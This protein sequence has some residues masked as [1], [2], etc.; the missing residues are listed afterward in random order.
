MSQYPLPN[1]GKRRLPVVSHLGVLKR[2]LEDEHCNRL[3]EHKKMR[4]TWAQT[5]FGFILLGTMLGGVAYWF[6]GVTL[7]GTIGIVWL[8]IMAVAWFFSSKIAPL[9]VSA[10]AA[11]PGTPY[12]DRAIRCADRAW[13]LLIE[14]VRQHYGQRVADMLTRPPVKLAPSKH[15][16]AFCTGRGWHDSVIVI[17]EG[18]VDAGMSDDEIVAVLAHELGHY[19]HGDVFIQ[20]VAGVLGAILSL[21]VTGFVQRWISPFFGRLHWIFRWPGLVLLFV[22]F[23]FA[24]SI[25]KVV[26]MFISRAREASADAFAADVTDDPCALARALRKLVVHEKKLAAEEAAKDEQLRLDDPVEF[27]RRSLVRTC[28]FAVLDALGLM[29]FVDT[30]ECLHHRE[31]EPAES[32]IG[33]LAQ[34][35]QRLNENHPPVEDRCAWLELAAGRACPLEVKEMPGKEPPAPEVSEPGQEPQ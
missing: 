7:L 31:S 5:L 9:A 15:A 30:L 20:S 10:Y 2:V 6:G 29:L 18:L 12:G 34:L 27:H 26:Q 14:H 21:T 1:G 3:V 13:T 8:S 22:C 4:Q 24:G 17:F 33:K 11:Q 28:E 25:A 16:N 19:F 32:L 35:W 23:R